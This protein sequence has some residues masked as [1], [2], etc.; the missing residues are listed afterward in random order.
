MHWLI[1]LNALIVIITIVIDIRIQNIVQCN[2]RMLTMRDECCCWRR[3]R[4]GLHRC[5]TRKRCHFA[6]VPLRRHT[7]ATATI[8]STLQQLCLLR[9]QFSNFKVRICFLTA[10]QTLILFFSLCKFQSKLSHDF[11]SAILLFLRL[12]HEKSVGQLFFLFFSQR[13]RLALLLVVQLL[14]SA[15]FCI[16]FRCSSFLLLP[17][18]LLLLHHHR[19]RHHLR[20]SRNQS[21]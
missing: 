19:H 10:K 21:I 16:L 3:R 1:L 6:F 14:A 12:R 17:L 7:L 15:G 11:V 9:S 18:L 5:D 13:R 20:F 4:R 8:D 2:N